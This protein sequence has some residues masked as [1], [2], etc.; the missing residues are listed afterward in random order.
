[1]EY[2]FLKTF[3]SVAKHLNFTKAALELHLTQAAVSRQ[4]KLLEESLGT[5]LLIRSPQKVI[6]T[7]SGKE[8]F[9]KGHYFQEW[10]LSEFSQEKTKEVR[11][12]ALQG[13]L[14]NWLVNKIDKLF[15]NSN[16]NLTISMSSPSNLT[17]MLEEGTLDM[18]LNIKNIQTENLTS[19]KLFQEEMV[20][21]SKEK[22][23]LKNIDRYRWIICDPN[24]YLMKY[25]RKKS[26]RILQ[27][28][29]T[30][31]ALR[32]V[33]KGVGISIIPSHLIIDRKK[34]Q[35]YPIEKFKKEFI[36]LTT[37]NY[38]IIPEHIKQFIQIL[39]GKST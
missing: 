19:L 14:E 25:C 37:F 29:S 34:L 17:K 8:L 23:S 7:S 27:V 2:R 18:I 35:I 9:Q 5:Q 24:D 11:I 10:I 15:K 20:L 22:L 33:E 21:I 6:L 13:I 16:F 3:I 12:G 4:I 31:A 38:K 1:M 30:T 28:N 39:S 36:Y 26:P 32:L